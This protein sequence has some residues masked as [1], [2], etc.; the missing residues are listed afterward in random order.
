MTVGI[1]SD[2]IELG[3]GECQIFFSRIPLNEQG[4]SCAFYLL[5]DFLQN[6]FIGLTIFTLEI[7]RRVLVRI[8]QRLLRV[9][10]DVRQGDFRFFGHAAAH[11]VLNVSVGIFRRV[12]GAVCQGDFRA[13]DYHR[14]V[15]PAV[16]GRIF[17]LA[18]NHAVELHT[19]FHLSLG[20]YGQVL[21]G[22]IVGILPLNRDQRAV[23]RR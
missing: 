8:D 23:C 19:M 5:V 17:E 18:I 20:V 3:A 4:H 1:K 21:N 16:Y 7:V 10:G 11:G 14:R 6:F 22:D 15:G 2:G 9:A 13:V 12:Q